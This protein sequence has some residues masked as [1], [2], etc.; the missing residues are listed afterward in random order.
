MYR[1]EILQGFTF[2][3][4]TVQNM[5]WPSQGC[6]VILTTIHQ[7]ERGIMGKY[8][9]VASDTGVN[10]CV[11]IYQDGEIIKYKKMTSTR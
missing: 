11:R 4:S 3:K 9:P 8:P 7:V 5:K 1:V 6:F 10:R 2:A